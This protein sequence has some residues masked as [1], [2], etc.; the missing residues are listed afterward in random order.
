[1]HNIFVQFLGLSYNKV[2]RFKKFRYL[3]R[4]LLKCKRFKFFF[5]F[6]YLKMITKIFYVY[7]QNIFLQIPT[8]NCSN[9][10]YFMCMFK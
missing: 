9:H 8:G 1:M 4:A 6:F 7:F 5:N 10:F 2:H 3:D